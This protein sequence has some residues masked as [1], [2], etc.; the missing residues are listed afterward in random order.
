MKTSSRSRARSNSKAAP[1]SPEETEDVRL[2][3]LP[4]ALNEWTSSYDGI[5]LGG[6]RVV[7]EI[8]QEIER[9]RLDGGEVKR[10]S[11]VGYVRIPSLGV[12]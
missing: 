12:W 3:V 4:A 11:I 7:Q 10:F 9:I 8:D 2:V 6:E 5:D 1:A